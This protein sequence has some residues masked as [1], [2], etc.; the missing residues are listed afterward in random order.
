[1]IEAKTITDEKRSARQIFKKMRSE[2]DDEERKILDGALLSRVIDCE[3]FNSAD[4]VLCYYPVKGE[5]NVL[6]IAEL[7]LKLGKEVAFPISHI[8]ERKLTFHLIDSVSDLKKGTYGIPEP[9]ENA[10]LLHDLKKAICIVPAL[11]FDKK[12][13]RLGYGGGYYDRFL[14][15]FSGASL[16]LAYDRFFVDELPADEYDAT[17]DIIITEKGENFFCETK[18]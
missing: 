9:S 5:P 10:P 1:M 15:K 4:T 6:P 17:V 2:I 8:A 3:T 18:K 7:A 16:G 13:K 14:S 12:G 11:A